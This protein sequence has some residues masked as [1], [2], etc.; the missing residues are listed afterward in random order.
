MELQYRSRNNDLGHYFPTSQELMNSMPDAE[1]SAQAARNI[2]RQIAAPCTPH[3]LN[4]E[5]IRQTMAMVEE[6]A[7]IRNEE[8]IQMHTGLNEQ[9]VARLLG[10]LD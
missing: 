8:L 7:A 10:L 1:A 2:S 5:E 4:N 6:E 9:R 3:S